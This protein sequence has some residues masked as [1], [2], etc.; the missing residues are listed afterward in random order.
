M[1]KKLKAFT[2][3]EL[4]VVMGILAILMAA[5]VNFYKPIRETFVDSSM[6]EDMRTTHDGILEYLSENIRYAEQ[7][8]IF[9]EGASYKYE[10][11]DSSDKPQSHTVDVDSPAKAF[12]AFALKYGYAKPNSKDI[13]YDN[14]EKVLKKVRII[15]LNRGGLY[16]INGNTQ[17]DKTKYYSGRIITNILSD[18]RY[19]AKEFTDNN[20]DRCGTT[21]PNGDSFMALGGAYYG[22]SSYD[23]YINMDKTWKESKDGKTYEYTGS[24]TFTVQNGLSNENGVIKNGKTYGNSTVEVKKEEDET[25]DKKGG[26]V[27]TLTTDKAVLTKNLST[28]DYYTGANKKIDKTASTDAAPIPAGTIQ[29]T[30]NVTNKNKNTYIVYLEPDETIR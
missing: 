7:M 29:A 11:K 10:Y 18:A 1:K 30:G 25:G 16:D 5:L 3:I 13:D 17:T 2:L 6:I 22:N 26:G 19:T 23:I 8:M 28:I 27:V 14:Y 20:G 9:D 12:E 24:L 15:V 21:N 4:I